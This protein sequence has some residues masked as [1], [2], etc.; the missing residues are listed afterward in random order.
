M[1][2]HTPTPWKILKAINT[3][4]VGDAIVDCNSSKNLIASYIAPSNAEF[5]VRAV[6][7]HEALLGA[8]KIGLSYMRPGDHYIV[9]GTDLKTVKS[10]IDQASGESKSK[11]K[12]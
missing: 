11:K 2:K 1:S 5:I 9:Y 8:A 10:A 3:P 4:E 12:R 7:S 6:N